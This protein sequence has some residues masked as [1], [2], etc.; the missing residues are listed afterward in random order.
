MT[1][2][3]SPAASTWTAPTVM[4]TPVPHKGQKYIFVLCPLKGVDKMRSAK[5]YDEICLLLTDY[6]S[7]K[8]DVSIEDF[9]SLLVKVQMTENI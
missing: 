4:D 9:Y 8:H 1:A 6:E 2:S 3:E 7:G 5:L